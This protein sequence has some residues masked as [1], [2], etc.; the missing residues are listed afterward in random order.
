MG[1]CSAALWRQ[2]HLGAR[3]RRHAVAGGSDSGDGTVGLHRRPGLEPHG[4]TGDL[5]RSRAVAPA[6]RIFYG[7]R[8]GLLATGAPAHPDPVL[9]GDEPSRTMNRDQD[10]SARDAPRC[11]PRSPERLSPLG[12]GAPRSVEPPRPRDHDRALASDMLFTRMR[13]APDATRSCGPDAP[14]AAQRL[15][16]IEQAASTTANIRHPG[17]ATGQWPPPGDLRW[18]SLPVAGR[19]IHTLRGVPRHLDT[20]PPPRRPLAAADLPPTGMVQTPRVADGCPE[21]LEVT[22]GAAVRKPPRENPPAKR[23]AGH[24]ERRGSTRRGSSRNEVTGSAPEVPSAT[25]ILLDGR[26]CDRGGELPLTWAAAASAQLH[27]FGF[28]LSS[29]P[30]R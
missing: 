28:G 15:L 30:N 3:G 26:L 7:R 8:A 16:S 9:A 21:T 1:C 13:C 11:V 27:R 29:R 14:H 6:G 18:V 10:S 24:A 25:E 23:S 17:A 20:A 19:L 12:L 2:T 4:F 5:A 22:F